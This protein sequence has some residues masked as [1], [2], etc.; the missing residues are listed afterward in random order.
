MANFTEYQRGVIALWYVV[1]ASLSSY[2]KLLDV[3]E[4]PTD[5]LSAGSLAWQ[6]LGIH[7]SHIGRLLDDSS[8]NAFVE[9][10]YQRADKSLFSMVFYDDVCYPKILSQLYDP[11]P[12]LFYQGNLE[13]LN[14]PQLAIVGTRHPSEYA[15]KITFDLAQY[16]VQ[17][18][19][20]VTS[21]L[22]LGVDS[23]AHRGALAQQSSDLQGRTVGVMGTGIDI[24]YPKQNQGLFYEI[25]QSGG[26]LVSELLPATMPSKHN[27]PRRNR[28]ITGLSQ[29]T[30]I[31]E[32]AIQSGSLI[33]ARL[34]AEQGKQVF[35]VP[36]RIDNPSS[37]GCHHLI[38]EGATLIYHPNQ[39][40][41]ELQAQTSILPTTF[42]QGS[43]LYDKSVVK[44]T[45]ITTQSN[46]SISQ[47][48]S[49]LVRIYELLDENLKDLDELVEIGEVSVGELLAKLTEL[50]IYGLVRSFGGRYARV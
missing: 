4:S 36:S 14:T 45:T 43:S 18:G 5:A 24:C 29:A 19:Y 1:N 28:L 46:T 30:I 44:T 40:I 35:C 50:E 16:L 8:I 15:Q 32:A 39:I 10:T 11:P 2:R 34:A 26:C 21:G 22:A 48:P 20:V 37:E 33:S 38:R 13:R 47:I 27:F 41:E 25:V 7:K 3:F 31:T 6:E 42:A 9:T 49:H 12:V 17:A 23:F